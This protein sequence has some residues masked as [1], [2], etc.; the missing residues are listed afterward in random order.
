MATQAATAQ[1]AARSTGAKQELDAHVFEQ[2]C[3][4]ADARLV[5]IANATFKHDFTLEKID[6]THY[7]LVM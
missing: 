3:A 5:D 2:V 6:S 1:T 4:L 7:N